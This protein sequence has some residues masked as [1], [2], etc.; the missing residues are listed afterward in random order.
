MELLRMKPEPKPLPPRAKVVEHLREMEDHPEYFREVSYALS[1]L[2]PRAFTD[3]ADAVRDRYE[4]K[5][6]MAKLLIARGENRIRVLKMIREVTGKD[7]A[8]ATE[9]YETFKSE[10]P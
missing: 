1:Q 7:H 8:K 6:T 3:I 4:G 2:D 10:I 9:M 5:L